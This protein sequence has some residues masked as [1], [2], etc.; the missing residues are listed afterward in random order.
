MACT[1]RKLD[2][3]LKVHC[4]DLL[5]DKLIT[6]AF[7]FVQCFG[8]NIYRELWFFLGG[9]EYSLLMGNRNCLKTRHNSRKKRSVSSIANAIENHVRTPLILFWGFFSH[10]KVSIP[11]VLSYLFFLSVFVSLIS[12][13]QIRKQ[14]ANNWRC[15]F[16]S[17]FLFF[18]LFSFFVHSR[19]IWVFFSYYPSLL[20]SL[21]SIQRHLRFEHCYF[22]IFNLKFSF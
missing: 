1:P 13:H 17:F 14:M 12:P 2:V 11:S 9:G 15:L 10:Q 19:C 4:S 5:P 7:Y 20:G 6:S 3:S 18:F 16:F 8:I 22:R 21:M